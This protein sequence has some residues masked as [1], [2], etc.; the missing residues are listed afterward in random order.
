MNHRLVELAHQA[1]ITF[2]NMTIDGEE[3][4]YQYVLFNDNIADDEAGCIAKFAELI[5]KE[6]CQANYDFLESYR[7]ACE[8]N[9]QIREI[10]G[11]ENDRE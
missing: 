9:S 8:I 10:F 1:G 5:V 7:E 3:Y 4:Q 11:L 6:C 2:K